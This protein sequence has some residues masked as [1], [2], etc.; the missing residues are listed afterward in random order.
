MMYAA[1]RS[2]ALLRRAR[3]ASAAARSASAS[4]AARRLG[5]RLGARFRQRRFAR[6]L[7][8]RPRAARGDRLDVRLPLDQRM[9]RLVHLG[10]RRERR[11]R[12]GLD[13]AQRVGGGGERLWVD[14]IRHADLPV[15]RLEVVRRRPRDGVRFFFRASLDLSLDFSSPRAARHRVARRRGGSAL[16]RALKCRNAR[17]RG[18]GARRR[19]RRAE[20]ERLRLPVKRGDAAGEAGELE[21]ER[22]ERSRGSLLFLRLLDRL[23]GRRLER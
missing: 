23:R 3:A 10:E 22:R 19:R 7:G 13:G 21:L 11:E 6:R 5:R 15:Y 17:E 16:S 9:Y 1:M 18:G 20:R 4:A 2:A 8:R 12:R 14:R